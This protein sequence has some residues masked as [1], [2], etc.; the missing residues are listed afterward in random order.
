MPEF[1]ASQLIQN[2]QLTVGTRISIPAAEFEFSYVRSGGPGGQNVNKVNTKAQ[3]RWKVVENTSLPADVK[4]RFLNKFGSRISR[5]GE[6]LIDSQR[7]RDQ[8]SNMADCLER[9]SAMLLS[10]EMPPKRRMKTKPSRGSIQRRLNDKRK[11][12]T[13]K[14]DRKPPK[15]DD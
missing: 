12:A 14:Q 11:Q 2:D 7:F 6:L 8:K 5:S 1:N 10:V 3:F 13:K 15:R 4:Q 9:L